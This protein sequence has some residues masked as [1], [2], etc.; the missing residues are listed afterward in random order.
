MGLFFH[1]ADSVDSMKKLLFKELN[2]DKDDIFIPQKIIVPNINVKRWLQLEIAK[3][4]EI[5]ANLDLSYLEKTL[6]TLLNECSN[7]KN[8]QKNMRVLNMSN[9]RMFFI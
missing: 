3:E 7:E 6:I 4:N 2:T 8:N 9:T 1:Y 5:C